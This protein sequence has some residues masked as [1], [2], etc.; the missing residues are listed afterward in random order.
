MSNPRKGLLRYQSLSTLPVAGV[1]FVVALTGPQ[2]AEAALWAG[3]TPDM[4]TAANWSPAGVPGV[5]VAADF[6]GGSAFNS[7]TYNAA[8]VGGGTGLSGL[9][10][11]STQTAALS[12]NNAGAVDIVG[13]RLGAGAGINIQAGAGAVSFGTVG[14]NNS[15]INLGS[16]TSNF[17]NNSASTATIGDFINLNASGGSTPTIAFSGTGG[18][19]L[20]GDVRN[21]VTAVV[22]SGG[23]VA[24][25][26]GA[27]DGI[28]TS[29]GVITINSGGTLRYDAANRIQN[30][31]RIVVNA[32]GTYNLNGRG[33]VV[34]AISG[35]GAIT[36]GTATLQLD[37]M[38]GSNFSGVMSGTG[39]FTL[40]GSLAQGVQTLSGAN[41]YT[42]A[43]T[44]TAGVL[45]LGNVS[46]LS[47]TSAVSLAGGTTLRSTIDGVIVN[48]PITVGAAGTTATIGAP[49]NAPGAGVASTFTLNGPIGGAGNVTFTSTVN[50][51][52]LSTI[53]LNGQSNYTGTTLMDTAGTTATQLV[54]KLGVDNALPTTTV[55]TIDGGNGTGSGRII[56]LD[57][58]GFD[59][60]LA[61]LN[62]AAGYSALTARN[63]RVTSS[64]A[65]TLT[66]NGSTNSSFGGLGTPTTFNGN[67]VNPSAQITGA[68]SLTK[69][70]TGTFTL[71]DGV[72]NTY[73]GLTTVNAGALRI[74]HA[75]SLGST[76]AGTVVNNNGR[77][78]LVNNI[79]TAAGESLTI[80]GTGGNFFG[81]LQSQ[82]GDN[83]WAGSVLIGAD[84]TRLGTA[85]GDDRVLRISGVIDD[86]AASHSI[87]VR[88]EFAN[89]I[90]ELS[91]ANTYGGATKI[92]N[93]TLR[94]AGGD[95]RLPT[96]T[97][98][99]FGVPA[100]AGAFTSTF[101]LNGF[102]Q[103]VA[104]L[105][106]VD[107][108]TA[109][110]ITLTNTNAT[111]KTFTVNM[112]AGT[113]TFGGLIT[114]NLALTKAGDGTL[115]LTGN[116][117]FTGNVT[118]QDGILNIRHDNA[119]GAS[120]KT[121][122]VAQSG[123]T[124]ALELQDN[125]S[126]DL[127]TL[128]TSGSGVGGNGVIRNV[129]GNNTITA[130]NIRLIGGNGNSE[131]QSDAGLLT[132]NGNISDDAGV[133]V[134]R[135]L[136]LDGASNGL[137]TGNMSNGDDV[138]SLT[139]NGAGTWTLTGNSTYTGNTA[140]N[141]GTLRVNG[142][143]GNTAVTINNGGTLGGTGTI[144]GTILLNAGG[145]LSPG[146]SI[147]S[148]ASGSNTWNGGSN[149][150]FE[151]RTDGTGTAGLDW[152]LLAIN[153]T[154][155]LSGAS[156]GNPVTM[157]LI[158][159]ANATTSGLLAV[160][161][162]AVAHTWAGFVT[163][164]GGVLAFSANKF[165]FD[166]SGFSNR[167]G[168]VFRVV[169]NGNNLDLNYVPIPEPTSLALLALGGAIL[170]GRRR[171]NA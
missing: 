138:L 101:D 170:V 124:P 160:W 107:T 41:T 130:T 28:S 9:N 16:G 80:S 106:S 90:L 83:T 64:T 45:E 8:G 148:L 65:A 100:N 53:L 2:K 18:W 162:P 55:L 38:D 29:G 76:A 88:H 5:G 161:D 54:V 19:L 112:A 153:G 71:L 119:L 127:G 97:T 139:K 120:T 67:P 43:T 40:R 23:L 62:T 49:T 74:A 48:A 98:L 73:T 117:T 128:R 75:D 34:G 39:G 140:V 99:D 156:A 58:N 82:N 104:G 79:T 50:Q 57:L 31:Q 14:P 103:T 66:I 141:D 121:V 135:T 69:A 22:V 136:I 84:E 3:T 35:A 93:G 169:Q 122:T 163:T 129:S 68:I 4:N 33:D 46:A 17:V 32:G 1:L 157:D 21:T 91:G 92:F 24:L 113:D 15:F 134:P 42:G 86:G 150:E 137:I 89:A 159:M 123:Q 149:F 151:F 59:Q 25:G 36:L 133:G 20:S 47:T 10:V 95:N 147:E 125:I 167:L 87:A 143:L 6:N 13:I 11:L 115:V 110:V 81:A 61:G 168:G 85:D 144:T 63:Q 96:S 26:A 164:T 158:T 114:G 111:A 116:N 118:V 60:T 154:L 27:G 171:R 51:N 44:V 126:V 12:I 166:V 70:G 145:T 30:G 131:W 77:L 52:A 132:V 108:G 7:L 105:S 78:E 56:S 152:D 72:G 102:N 109:D 142:S 94:I 165:T 146:A 155:N 37:D